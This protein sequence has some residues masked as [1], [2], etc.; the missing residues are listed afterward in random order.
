MFQI[1]NPYTAFGCN[2]FLAPFNNN[3]NNEILRLFDDNNNTLK[4]KN[5]GWDN[6]VH[7]LQNSL[8]SR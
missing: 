1:Y 3:M 8:S 5:S 6:Y 7:G 2:I 4:S